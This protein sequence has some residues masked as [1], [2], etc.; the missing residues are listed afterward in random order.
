[1]AYSRGTNYDIVT[2]DCIK[3]DLYNL[4]TT[5]T[6]PEVEDYYTMIRAYIVV[7]N[8]NRYIIKALEDIYLAGGAG[9]SAELHVTNDVTVLLA[10][11][12]VRPMILIPI[13]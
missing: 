12:A 8:D 10:I 13:L 3:D 6:P 5:F 2:V 1:M 4:L 7:A 9:F 11:L